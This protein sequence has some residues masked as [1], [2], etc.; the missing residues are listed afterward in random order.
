MTKPALIASL[1][2]VNSN[3][4]NSIPPALWFAGAAVLVIVAMIM[5]LRRKR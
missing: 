5:F 1:A 3:Q 2:A 4:G